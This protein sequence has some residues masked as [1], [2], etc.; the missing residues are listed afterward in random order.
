MLA[1]GDIELEKVILVL[2]I[3]T[4]FHKIVIKITGLRDTIENCEF[5]WT[6][7]NNSWRHGAI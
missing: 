4:K 1:Y 5:S 3:V 6:R 2:N 7:G